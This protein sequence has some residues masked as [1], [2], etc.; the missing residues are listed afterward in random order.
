MFNETS[1]GNRQVGFQAG[2]SGLSDLSGCGC[3]PIPQ[4]QPE[5]SFLEGIKWNN[6][7]VLVVAGVGLLLFLNKR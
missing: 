7:L 2:L 6:P 4:P 1:Q 5:P 3:E